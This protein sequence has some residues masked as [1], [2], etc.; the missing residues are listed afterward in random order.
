ML[1]SVKFYDT[2]LKRGFVA[3]EKA[4]KGHKD[5]I[6]LERA[7]STA[8]LPSLADGA[9]ID[10][11][12]AE[13]ERG[14]RVTQINRV[15]DNS[16]PDDLPYHAARV[17]WFDNAKGWGFVRIFGDQRDYYLHVKTLQAAGM[18]HLEVGQAIAVAVQDNPRG[19]RVARVAA[20][21]DME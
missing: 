4:H 19:P 8:G 17:K 21:E 11:E 7:L 12:V 6:L 9:L 15:I 20:W 2:R 1:A 13:T 16:D 3:F 5:A 14:L 10:V 18:G